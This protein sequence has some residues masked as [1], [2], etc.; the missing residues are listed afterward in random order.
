MVEGVEEE[1]E[2]EVEAEGDPVIEGAEV[3]SIVLNSHSMYLNRAKNNSSLILRMNI[4][5]SMELNTMKSMVRKSIKTLITV[6][7][8]N[9][10]D[11]NNSIKNPNHSTKLNNSSLYQSKNQLRVIVKSLVLTKKKKKLL[12]NRNNL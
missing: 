6:S 7:S 10:K 1:E 5:M 12:T 11:I 2:V 9:M 3:E 4:T 8:N